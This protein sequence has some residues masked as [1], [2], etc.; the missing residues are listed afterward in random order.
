MGILLDG[1]GLVRGS[2]AARVHVAVASETRL[3]GGGIRFLLSLPF[4]P[5]SPRLFAC[6]CDSGLVIAYDRE[7]RTIVP[8]RLLELPESQTIG[9]II[10]RTQR[11]LNDDLHF[12]IDVHLGFGRSNDANC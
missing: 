1:F 4:F 9:T 8:K 10:H 11:Y 7:C 6:G 5:R 12:S 3:H 2:R